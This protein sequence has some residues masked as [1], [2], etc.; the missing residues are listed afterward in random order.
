MSNPSSNKIGLL[1]IVLTF[2]GLGLFARY[3]MT[4][5]NGPVNSTKPI[6][7][8]R[9]ATLVFLAIF[10]LKPERAK[11]Y[12]HKNAKKL[13]IK[14]DVS[15]NLILLGLQVPTLCLVIYIANKYYNGEFSWLQNHLFQRIDEPSLPWNN[16]LEVTPLWGVHYFGDLSHVI[17]FTRFENPWSASFAGPPL[18]ANLISILGVFGSNWGLILFFMLNTFAILTLV[19]VWS[20]SEPIWLKTILFASCFPLNISSIYALDR[21]NLVLIAVCSTGIAIGRMYRNKQFDNLSV[22]FL[23]CAVSLKI[24]I[25]L[26]ILLLALIYRTKWRFFIKVSACLA[27][28]NLLLLLTYPGSPIT[29][30]SLI[31]RNFFDFTEPDFLNYISPQSGSLFYLLNLFQIE[32]L[33]T[34]IASSDLLLFV[35]C[36]WLLI[37]GWICLQ[38]TVPTWLKLFL[39]MSSFQMATPGAP[40]VM[41]WNIVGILLLSS[42]LKVTQSQINKSLIEKSL[43]MVAWAAA[44]TCSIPHDAR[45]WL[46]PILLTS[47]IVLT[48]IYFGISNLKRIKIEHEEVV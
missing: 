19:S 39:A 15:N 41:T 37:V 9:A 35:T 2:L 38:K 25:V 17:A 20:K 33:G 30:L 27:G 34:N 43:E 7:V 28:L 10:L 1:T 47:L 24:Y 21:G 29:N 44:L 12:K 26:I 14:S 3:G 16:R 11:S 48:L 31:V 45:F 18:S 40:Y 46:S 5:T 22:L 36:I 32:I 42:R 8:S 23:I 6:L 4:G 13:V